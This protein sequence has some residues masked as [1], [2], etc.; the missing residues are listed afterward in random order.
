MPDGVLLRAA[1]VLFGNAQRIELEMPQCRLR[2]ARF[3]GTRSTDEILDNRQFYGHAFLLLRMA[4]RFLRDT[5]P[6][7]GRFEYNQMARI[8]TP[9]YPQPATRESITNA[10]CHRDYSIGGGSVG[11]AV[12]DGRLEVTYSGSLAFGLKTEKSFEPHESLLWNPLIAR[13][14]YRRGIIEERGGGIP[15]MAELMSSEGLPRP[16]IDDAGGC[17]RVVFRNREVTR[18]QPGWNL[19]EN[20][21]QAILALLDQSQKGLALREIRARLRPPATDH[22]IRWALRALRS[23]GDVRSYGH[24]LAAKWQLCPRPN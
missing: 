14:L 19:V 18:P 2:V 15:K 20:R 22:Q 12:Y 8:D 7:A 21:K 23:D 6:I 9:L 11:V 13:T 5:L 1:V 24:G 16:E 4:E 17:V 10:L 3:L